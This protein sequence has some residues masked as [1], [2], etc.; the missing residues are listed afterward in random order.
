M[1]SPEVEWELDLYNDRGQVWVAD[2][3]SYKIEV[4]RD[5]WDPSHPIESFVAHCETWIAETLTAETADGIVTACRE[6][7]KAEW[8]DD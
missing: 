4:I 6:A 3:G 1:A 5:A 2:W 7:L 8:V